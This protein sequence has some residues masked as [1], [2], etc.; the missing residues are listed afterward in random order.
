MKLQLQHLSFQLIFRVDSLRSDWLELRAV[1]GTLESLLQHL[2]SKGSI[3]RS[4]A[5]SLLY[6]PALKS[7]HDYWKN[8]SFDIQTFVGKMTSP[9][10]NILS[11]FVT[12]YPFI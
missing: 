11:R 10:F 5:L 2:S 1:Q 4:L 3:L 8:Y 12:H 6:G 9:L 7:I